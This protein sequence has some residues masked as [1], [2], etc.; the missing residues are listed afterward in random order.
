VKL[1][2][3]PVRARLRAP[4]AAGWGTISER[5]LVLVRLESGDGTV[6]WGEAAP[7]P[8]YDGVSME[9]VRAALDAYGG[10]L[11]RRGD[12]P[13]EQLLASCAE[14]LD[15]PEALAAVELALWD[16]E[17]R[18]RGQPV[19]Q[20]LGGRWDITPDIAKRYPNRPAVAVNATVGAKDPHEAAAEVAA[21]C[22][23]GFRCVKVKVALGDDAARLNAAR[24]AGGDEMTIRIDANGAWRSVEEAVAVLGELA[25]FGIELCEEPVHGLE[26]IA[27][28][29]AASPIPIALDET[30]AASGAFERRVCDATC[31][32]IAR[33]GGL[34]GLLERATQAR[35]AGYRI[36]LAST[37][38]GPLAIAA[39]LH[40]AVAIRPELPCGLAT[41]GGFADRPD[42]L[43]PRSGLMSPPLGS[44]LGEGLREW[45]GLDPG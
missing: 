34:T 33:S 4:F 3:E 42:P 14:T 6:G 45:Y 1:S 7:L 30:A 19:W 39:A 27:A 15:L 16:L 31:L 35:A 8:G 13:R 10:E 11:A 26:E 23:A 29:A 20:L 9:E 41:L 36:Y 2:V 40:A 21:A 28:V 44:G 37:L 43:P 24:E 32:K 22:A 18:R 5:E 38:D 12:G 17:G 25:R